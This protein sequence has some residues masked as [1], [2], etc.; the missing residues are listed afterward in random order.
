[1]KGFT[2]SQKS[3]KIICRTDYWLIS[4]NLSDF[5]G[6]TEIVSAVGTD[7][8]AI[9]LDFGKLENELK[10]RGIWKMNCSLLDD[11]EY[12]TM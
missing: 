2:W 9:S 4:N 1:M 6:S 12:V 5:V 8:D 10:G 3:P 7:N 11:E